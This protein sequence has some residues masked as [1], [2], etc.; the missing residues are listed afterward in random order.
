MTRDPDTTPDQGQLAARFWVSASGFWRGRSARRAWPVTLLI[1]AIVVL[2]LAVQYGMNLWYR[3]FFDAF[4]RKDG[5]TVWL[6][7]L[8]F[9][10]LVARNV[11]LSLDHTW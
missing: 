5:P 9:V 10:P 2:E 6:E 8:I 11:L 3:H 1:V 7:T 4:G